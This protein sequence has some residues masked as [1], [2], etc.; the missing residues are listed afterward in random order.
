MEK[1]KYLD[2]LFKRI[3]Y[4][5]TMASSEEPDYEALAIEHEAILKKIK[6][7]KATIKKYTPTK[8]DLDSAK[9]KD[10]ISL[11]AKK[12][13]IEERQLKLDGVLDSLSEENENFISIIDSISTINA[14]IA[15]LESEDEALDKHKELSREFKQFVSSNKAEITALKKELGTK[16]N[17]KKRS[18]NS[19]DYF[20]AQRAE[21][22][23]KIAALEAECSAIEHDLATVKAY[24]TTGIIKEKNR[25]KSNYEEELAILT[26]RLEAIENDP[27]YLAAQIKNLIEAKKDKSKVVSMLNKIYEQAKQ[28]PYMSVV[29]RN[30]NTAKLVEEY[31]VKKL[32]KE[33]IEKRIHDTNY[34]LKELPS[35][36]SR[37]SSI[38][39]LI[40]LYTKQIAEHEGIIKEN[41]IAIS[42]LA[43]DAKLLSDTYEENVTSVEAY[44]EGLTDVSD[45]AQAHRQHE[46]EKM[47][48][49]LADEKSIIGATKADIVELIDANENIEKLITDLRGKI[50]DLSLE[51][52]EMLNKQM[53]RN[54]Y[55]DVIKKNRDEARLR[56]VK[57]E[58]HYILKRS[59]YRHYN[60]S[61]LY[62]DISQG[63]KTI[64]QPK[65]KAVKKEKQPK[66]QTKL[67]LEP[68]KVKEQE[69]SQP[70]L[71]VKTTK[72][73]P[74]VTPLNELIK[75]SKDKKQNAK[76]VTKEEIHESVSQLE[77]TMDQLFPKKQESSVTIPID[78]ASI[79]DAQKA[80]QENSAIK[81]S[82]DQLQSL[83]DSLQTDIV[84]SLEE[85]K[86]FAK[87]N[88]PETKQE[89]QTKETV[90]EMPKKEA[91]IEIK[92]EPTNNA[93]SQ[94]L[95]VIKSEPIFAQEKGK[96][97]AAQKQ[98]VININK[99]NKGTQSIELDEFTPFKTGIMMEQPVEDVISYSRAA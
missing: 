55:Y 2:G 64:Y 4:L 48:N 45:P 84:G 47:R 65:E 56:A 22:E 19:I 95:R 9:N 8:A 31:E 86:A 77:K 88:T 51:A 15:T 29:I 96:V 43:G 89:K 32:E 93:A 75:T 68:I 30:G 78:F 7:I 76:I 97:Q 80:K 99:L 54:N 79:V 18:Q 57:K 74:K 71:E 70:K 90:A 23:E 60:I 27:I 61:N 5:A 58:I 34:S 37:K 63:I 26:D 83:A 1:R 92:S 6:E 44:A 35:E 53:A 28:Q 72:V 52:T 66:K 40:N 33:E 24:S 25:I 12:D 98:K 94:R 67:I 16:Q 46:Y 41:N 20:T 36:I 3:N 73:E 39:K 21:L 91:S 81:M 50:T 69:K 59:K 11:S 85:T 82:F 13:E 87:K 62:S 49:V 38:E 17:A 10:R 42:A 14:S